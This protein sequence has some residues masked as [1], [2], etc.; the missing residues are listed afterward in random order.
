M[1]QGGLRVL[2]YPDVDKMGKQLKYASGCGIPVAAILGESEVAAGTVTIKRLADGRVVVQG[3]VFGNAKA[4]EYMGMKPKLLPH[5]L[6]SYAKLKAE[7]DLVL[8]LVDARVGPTASDLEVAELLR[9][10]QG[11]AGVIDMAMGDR[12]KGPGINCC[13]THG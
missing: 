9:Q 11:A 12:I 4:A 13:D 8:F 1:R 6:E 5:V 3:K 10:R 2:V 7:A